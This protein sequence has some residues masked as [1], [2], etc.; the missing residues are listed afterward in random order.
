MP[1]TQTLNLIPKTPFSQTLNLIPK[2]QTS[3]LKPHSLNPD[4]KPQK[5]CAKLENPAK[6]LENE[7]Q[8]WKSCTNTP[9]PWVWK[10]HSPN[11]KAQASENERKWARPSQ[12]HAKNSKNPPRT[13]KMSPKPETHAQTPQ[14]HWSENCILQT[15]KPKPQKMKGNE[16][17]HPMLMLKTPTILRNT[18]K[19]S[20]KPENPAQTPQK[21]KGPPL[22]FYD[23]T[24]LWFYAFMTSWFHDF[25]ILWC[26]RKG[27]W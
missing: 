5:S 16:L 3:N 2:T 23:F 7:H 27:C 6:N 20:P 10:L 14:N 4:V 21:S 1:K 26:I 24:I 22:C 9:K 17:S 19:M 8:T 18:W 15:T 13:W 25:M 12:A 11:H